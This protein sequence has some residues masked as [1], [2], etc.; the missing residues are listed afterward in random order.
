M[1]NFINNAQ[2]ADFLNDFDN[3]TER[4]NQ[5]DNKIY[6]TS[7]SVVLALGQMTFVAVA[8]VYG[9]MQLTTGTDEHGNPDVLMFMKNTGGAQNK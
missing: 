4:A 1:F 6:N 3:A 2:I 7:D 8:E 9:S 5:I